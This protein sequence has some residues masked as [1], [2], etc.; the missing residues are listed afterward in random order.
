MG[1]VISLCHTV[2]CCVNTGNANKLVFGAGTRLTIR[3]SKSD[4]FLHSFM[5][6]KLLVIESNFV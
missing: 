3:T 2:F 5:Y 4:Y 6:I 1:H